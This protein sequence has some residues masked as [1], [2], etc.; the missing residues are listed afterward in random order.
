MSL[1]TDHPIARW[2]A[3]AAACAVIGVVALT[4]NHVAGADPGLPP[5][6]AAQLLV[7]VQQANLKG[8]SGTVVQTANLGLPQISLGGSTE[9]GSSSLSSLVSG[10]HTWR[11]WLAGPQQQRLALVGSLG[12][13]DVIRNGRDLWVWSSKDK[14]ATHTTLPAEAATPPA[15]T[16]TPEQLPRTPQEAAQ[17]ALAAV[18]P[19]TSVATSGASVVAGQQAYDLVLKPKDSASLV[20]SVRISLD[21]VHHV[22]LRVQVFST[23]TASP[24]FQVGFTQV[25]FGK[26]DA[27][28][29]AFNPPPGTKVSQSTLGGDR[30]ASGASGAEGAAGAAGAKPG[31]APD[32]SQ[33]KV[34]GTG[35]TAVA[36]ARLPQPSADPAKPGGGQGSA[37]DIAGQLQRV[38]SLLPKASGAWGSGRVLQG[39]LFTVVVTDDGR[40]AVGAV[41]PDRVYAALAAK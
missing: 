27:R 22:P 17:L 28:Q 20:A 10:T 23:K 3:P 24:V 15:K 6:S 25:D 38:L 9:G 18:E 4:A 13:S 7:D 5:R 33:P 31:S 2:A 35:W 34:V 19:T 14:T 16:P 36:V 29:F 37:A 41:A 40:V 21:A 32:G 26:P 8:L 39:T 1:F 30:A 12:E 11:V